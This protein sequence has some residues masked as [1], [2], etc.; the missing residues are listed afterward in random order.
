MLDLEPTDIRGLWTTIE[1][2]WLNI[3]PEFIHI[4]LLHFA[5]LEEILHDTKH[6]GISVAFI[7]SVI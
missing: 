7:L 2:A 1:M 5:N 3:S 6:I 4:E